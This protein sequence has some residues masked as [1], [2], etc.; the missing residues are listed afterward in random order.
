MSCMNR[1]QQQ[2]DNQPLEAVSRPR[3][4][5]LATPEPALQAPAAGTK[6]R[7]A[8]RRAVETPRFQRRQGPYGIA[9]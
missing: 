5:S 1:P 9:A 2:P 6:A 4:E 8:D 3:P 7:A